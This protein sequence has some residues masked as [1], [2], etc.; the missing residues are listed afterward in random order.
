MP[1]E[2]VLNVVLTDNA[3]GSHPPLPVT[4]GYRDGWIEIRPQGHGELEAEAGFGA[5]V[6][7]ELY[8]GVL[9]V[10]VANDINSGERQIIPLDGAREDKRIS[11]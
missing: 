4:I 8:G 1:Q 2:Q 10:I 9:R 3:G 5:P 7:M 6:T 11:P